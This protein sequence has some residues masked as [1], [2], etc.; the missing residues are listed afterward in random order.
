MIG[1]LLLAHTEPIPTL[2][3]H[4]WLAGYLPLLSLYLSEISVLKLVNFTEK[5]QT[6][7][8][9]N[10]L[11]WI[12]A[13]EL[14]SWFDWCHPDDTETR[15]VLLAPGGWQRGASEWEGL[16]AVGAMCQQ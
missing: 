2:A 5:I 14:D 10:Q 15:L 16:G 9:L 8:G 13:S 1:A 12:I 11:A 7:V 6:A 4:R 3:E